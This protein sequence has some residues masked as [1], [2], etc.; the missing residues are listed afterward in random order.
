MVREVVKADCDVKFDETAA[1]KW[2]IPKEDLKLSPKRAAS[3][4]Q[5]V[6]INTGDSEKHPSASGTADL[7]TSDA[8]AVEQQFFDPDDAQRQKRD[9]LCFGLR[10][11]RCIVWWALEM[12]PT[13]Y[14][15]QDKDGHWWKQLRRAIPPSLSH[16]AAALIK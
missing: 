16:L 13:F 10:N 2:N 11:L 15:W 7:H 9:K 8:P 3:R 5:Q 6:V 1:K 4:L 14:E 12:S